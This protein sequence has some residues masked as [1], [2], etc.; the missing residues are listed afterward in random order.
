MSMSVDVLKFDWNT[1]VDQIVNSGCGNRHVVEQVLQ[2]F[3]EKICDKY[4]IL[5]DDH[6]VEDE[7]NRMCHAIE[8]LFDT[9]DCFNTI[10][11]LDFEYVGGRCSDKS[12]EKDGELRKLAEILELEMR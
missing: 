6:R 8:S 1:I 11:D 4:V 3:G 12:Y 5:L 7:F 9:E 10:Y 2:M